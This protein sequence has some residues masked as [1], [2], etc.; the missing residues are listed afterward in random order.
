MSIKNE[1]DSFVIGFPN[2][3]FS[4]VLIICFST[5]GE[6]PESLWPYKHGR[7]LTSYELII[8]C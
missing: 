8:A 7:A 3:G 4:N 2:H 6:Y 5:K 1:S